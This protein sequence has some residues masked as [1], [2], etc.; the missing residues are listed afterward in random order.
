MKYMWKY[1]WIFCDYIYI[2]IWYIS[3]LSFVCVPAC[4]RVYIFC[5]VCVDICFSLSSNYLC[6]LKHFAVDSQIFFFTL[7]IFF[8]SASNVTC[9]QTFVLPNILTAHVLLQKNFLYYRLSN[10]LPVWRSGS[11][12]LGHSNRLCIKI[13]LETM[14]KDYHNPWTHTHTHTRVTGLYHCHNTGRGGGSTISR[15]R[16]ARRSPGAPMSARTDTT[17][18]R[19]VIKSGTDTLKNDCRPTVSPTSLG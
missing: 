14:K 10:L 17:F 12:A 19:G 7:A 2:Y 11:L 5:R 9:C 15:H 1:S 16:Q 4:A 6:D 8:L 18:N 3:I 13:S